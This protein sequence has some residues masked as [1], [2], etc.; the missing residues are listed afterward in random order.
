MAEA[1]SAN[2]RLCFL[3][4]NKPAGSAEIAGRNGEKGPKVHL[5]GAMVARIKLPRTAAE[6]PAKGP[7][8]KP[9]IG[10]NTH[11]RLKNL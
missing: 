4:V 2:N 10:E 7:I 6:K 3:R 11:P 1:I 5:Y 9:I 8:K